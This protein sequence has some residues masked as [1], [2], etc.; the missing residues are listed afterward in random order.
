MAIAVVAPALRSRRAFDWS[1]RVSGSKSM[2][3]PRSASTH[4]NTSCRMRLSSSSMS[5]VWLTARAVRY[6]TCRLLRARASQR[7]SVSSGTVCPRGPNS[8]SSRMARTI[9]ELSS[10][11]AEAMISTSVDTGRSAGSLA[12]ASTLR[13]TRIWS[14][15]RRS[16]RSIRRLLTN[17]PLELLRS[18]TVNDSPTRRISAWRLETSLSSSW[19]VLPASRPM[20]T[21]PECAVRS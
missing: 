17:V 19:I 6:I 4:S 10:R 1:V 2:M 20:L 3:Q 15:L 14:P 12:K 21:A 18:A 16:A 11:G 7:L 13:P 9:R 8:A 5:S